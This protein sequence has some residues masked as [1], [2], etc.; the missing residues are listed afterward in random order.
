MLSHQ[1]ETIVHFD[2]TNLPPKQVHFLRRPSPGDR[3][4]GDARS[5]K[6]A[7]R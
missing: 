3:F 1:G 7:R 4:P 6:M 2:K 5:A